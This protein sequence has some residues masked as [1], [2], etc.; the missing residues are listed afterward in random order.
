MATTNAAHLI[1]SPDPAIGA[2]V[3]R[4]LPLVYA[5]GAAHDLDRPAHVRAGSG[6]A[7]LGEQLVVVQDD[8]NFLALIDPATG[9]ARAVP[10]PPGHDGRRQFDDRR[11]NKHLKLDLEACFTAPDEQ[12]GVV[13]VA[14]G[15]GS[16][17]RRE[18]IVTAREPANAAGVTVHD[19]ATL[20]RALRADPD[21][22]PGEMNVEGAIYADGVVRLFAR[23]NG[24]PRDG[25]PS[26]NATCELDWAELRHYLTDPGAHPAPRPHGVI[27]YT[28]GEI[29]G[30]ALGFTDAAVVGDQ[31][32]FT[33][34]SAAAEDSP[35]VTRD[36][37]VSGSAI[38]V[39]EAGGRA[40]WTLL[41]DAAGQ[42]FSAKVEGVLVI[43]G[44]P[45]RLH[46][47]IDQDDPD[48]PSELCVVELTGPWFTT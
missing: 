17:S 13:A 34:F 16:T 9:E 42:P 4:R 11:G 26:I 32:R 27:Q 22:A 30:L 24:G 46:V 36:G 43:P 7:R 1:A 41:L 33:L 23:G 45:G 20:Y 14:I 37:R 10:L 18:R 44:D 8:A 29:D 38:G 35:D 39:L 2:R 15:S 6:I 28:L 12:G 19:A 3:V 31:P 40:R 21:F 5:D 48:A 25:H 47:V